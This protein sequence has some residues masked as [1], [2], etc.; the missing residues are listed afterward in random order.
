MRHVIPR[1][2][3][4]LTL[5]VGGGSLLLFT[6]FLLFGTPWPIDLVRSDPE[7]LCWDSLLCVVFF[8]Q[9]SGMIRRS[10]KECMAKRIPAVYQPALY[11]IASGVALFA[12]IL[13]WQPTSRS[14]FH[15]HGL[16]RWLSG[17]VALAAIAG[18]VWGVRALDG[19]DPFGIRPIAAA[20]RG[21]PAPA[22]PFAVRGPYRY[23]RHPLYLAMLLLIW[24]TPR[25][26]TDQLLFNVLWTSWIIVA[27][28]LEE[29]DLRREFGET[30]R[31]YQL[32]VPMLLPH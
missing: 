19:L 5:A 24:S 28:R 11:S 6:F 26:S 8:L 13:L 4:V 9:H 17:C 1:L 15:L 32:R 31:Q 3:I 12:L 2:I 18:F 29:R 27:T 30:Y 16:A 20:L 10:A 21:A 25:F 23:V 22:S 14:L 7:R